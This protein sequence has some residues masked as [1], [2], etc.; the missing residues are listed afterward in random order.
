MFKTI[1]DFEVIEQFLVQDKPNI[2][3]DVNFVSL[4]TSF[5]KFL[6]K[7]CIL[8]IVNYEKS[9]KS[10]FIQEF[11]TGLGDTEFTIVQ[12]FKEPFKCEIKDINPFT[13]YCLA[14]E[15]QVK[16]RKYRLKN[17]L[18]FAFL[19]DYL[20][21]WQDLSI[22]KKPRIQY[23]K[24]NFNGIIFKSWAKL[25]DYLLPFTDVV[26]SDN[27][28]LSRTD[29]VEWNLK[30]ILIKLDKTTQVKYNLTII[31]F[32]GTKYKLDGKK[33]YDNLISFKQD[34]RL[35]FEL[36]FILSREREIK[37]HDRGIFMN[38]L[39]IDSGDSFNYFDSRNN[40]VT[41]GTKISFNSLT[42]PDN[43]NSSKAALEN[44]TAI[45]NN[46]KQKFPDTNTFGILKNRLLDI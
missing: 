17:G 46:I 11:R 1:I 30:A 25:S 34:N 2:L 13:F 28:L 18:L 21:V 15:L 32:E 40:V 3:D 35:K 38:Y 31:S 41:S 19:D 44:L 37:E 33:E 42:S 5:R 24:E 45:I 39:W 7:E 26:I 29:L 6:K 20:S 4:W 14:E 22:T 10:R 9:S 12:K 36:S 8:E 27:F 16:R 23:I 43:F